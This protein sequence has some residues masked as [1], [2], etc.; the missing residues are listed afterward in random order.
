MSYILPPDAAI[1]ETAVNSNT[2]AITAN[3]TTLVSHGTRLTNTEAATTTNATNITSNDTDIAALQGDVAT[4]QTSVSTNGVDIATNTSGLATLNGEKGTANGI[5]TLDG[6][7]EVPLAQLK[8]GVANGIA[9]LDGNGDVPLSQ[10]GNVPPSGATL[11]ANTF[12]DQQTVNVGATSKPALLCK[13]DIDKEGW[14]QCERVFTGT[15]NTTYNGNYSA[16]AMTFHNPD[17]WTGFFPSYRAVLI[18]MV[19]NSTSKYLRYFIEDDRVFAKQHIDASPTNFVFSENDATWACQ[20]MYCQNALTVTSDK[21]AKMKLKKEKKGLK[22]L[23]KLKPK[24][25]KRKRNGKEGNRVHHGL[26][27]QDV[28]E[29][30]KDP[31]FVDTDGEDG[32]VCKE[33]EYLHKKNEKGEWYTSTET[34]KNPDGTDYYHYSLRM[35]EFIGPLIAAVGELDT[36]LTAIKAR[37]AKLEKKK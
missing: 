9:T 29:L 1:V 37:L 32:F 22:F 35:G 17:G 34:R 6:S 12:T 8:T 21:K 20:N 26:V 36:E 7:S 27:A 18:D 33:V 30:L 16:N 4:L 10:L 11:G 28:E 25:W 5:A 2:D 15:P 14:I 31:Q 3:S 13:A 19:S 24:K 23:T